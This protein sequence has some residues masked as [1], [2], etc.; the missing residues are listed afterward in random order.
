M[1]RILLL[2][3]FESIRDVV[4]GSKTG[5]ETRI[6]ES[7]E[8]VEYDEMNENVSDNNHDNLFSEVD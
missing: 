4:F 6:H 8:N 1:K 7:D 2:T 5:D 3:I